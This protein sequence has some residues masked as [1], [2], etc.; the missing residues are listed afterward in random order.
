M[1]KKFLLFILFLGAI[2]AQA[3]GIRNSIL[4]R[5]S[6]TYWDYATYPDPPVVAGAKITALQSDTSG[7]II[8]DTINNVIDT[9]YVFMVIT[10]PQNVQDTLLTDKYNN[11]NGDII[12]N[13]DSINYSLFPKN[14]FSNPLG[15]WRLKCLNHTFPTSIPEIEKPKVTLYPNP[16]EDFVSIQL[17]ENH[18]H[19]QLSIYN[20]TGQV[21]SQK[22]ITQPNQQIPI[23]DLGNGMYIFVIQ[24]KDKIIGRQ[25]VVVTR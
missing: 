7:M 8:I 23:T 1:K 16:A 4:G 19:A 17:P 25:R 14:N 22:Q 15:I 20:L 2:T 13:C 9:A 6:G 18:T 24:T 21:I 5:Y 10:F 3:Q 11:L 12:P